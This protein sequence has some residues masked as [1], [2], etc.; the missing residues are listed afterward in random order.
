MFKSEHLIGLQP[1]GRQ[2]ITAPSPPTAP[3]SLLCTACL[4]AALLTPFFRSPL[5]FCVHGDINGVQQNVRLSV[6]QIKACERL[7]FFFF[8]T[9]MTS[10]VIERKLHSLWSLFCPQ[11]E[12]LQ[13]T[14]SGEKK[15]L[16]QTLWHKNERCTQGNMQSLQR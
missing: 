14:H 6:T 4:L 5:L 7:F 3:P 2:P 10:N 12:I 9:G 8:F 1:P 15:V 13:E 11:R 16:P